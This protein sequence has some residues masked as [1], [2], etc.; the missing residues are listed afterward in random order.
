MADFAIG[1]NTFQ[2]QHTIISSAYFSVMAKDKRY[3]NVKNL[4]SAGHIKAFREIFDVIPKS[5]V[6]R[7]LGMNNV[8]FT[9]LIKNVDRFVVKDVNRIAKLVGVDEQEFMIL[10]MK[11]HVADKASKR[12][13]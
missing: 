7:D 8:R 6:A 9:K 4:F 5:V 12:R 13:K 10:L 3:T 2:N 11:Q 1:N